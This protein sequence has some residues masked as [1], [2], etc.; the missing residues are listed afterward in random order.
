ME[1][2]VVSELMFEA[3]SVPALTYGID[4][5]FSYNYNGGRS[6]LV[7]SSGHTST[8]LIPVLNGKGMTAMTTR[9]NWGGSQGTDLMLKLLQLKYPA[10]PTKMAAHTAEGLVHDHCYISGDYKEEMRDYLKPEK[11]E[12]HDRVVQFPFTEAVVVEKSQEELDRLAEKR[13]ESGRRLQEQ[14][15]KARLEKV[16][17]VERST[18]GHKC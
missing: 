2:I 14:A 16:C 8:H 4:A 12:E 6:G 7:V 9:L 1:T 17:L 18:M 11:L 10:F 13:K 3:Y 5:L 15:A